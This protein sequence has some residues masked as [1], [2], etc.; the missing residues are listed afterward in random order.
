MGRPEA[1]PDDAEQEAKAELEHFICLVAE[2]MSALG[3]MGVSGARLCFV[4]RPSRQA[5]RAVDVRSWQKDAAKP[6]A[7]G[8]SWGSLLLF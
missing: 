1:S 7:S 2:E 3:W 4:E 6:T 8:G 5:G